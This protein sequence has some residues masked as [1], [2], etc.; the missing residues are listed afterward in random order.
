MIVVLLVGISAAMMAP[1]IMNTMAISRASRCQYDFARMLRR[2]RSEAIGTGRAQLIDIVSA[3]GDVQ[4]N[5][6]IGDSSSC[7]RSLWGAIVGVMNPVDRVWQSDYD[8][9]G[10]G[11]FVA[12]LGPGAAPRQICFEPDGDRFDRPS[13]AGVFTRSPGILTVTLD[14]HVQGTTGVDVQR[15]IVIPQFG[16]P[17]V[18]R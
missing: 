10:N 16:A 11:V 17:R 14:R 12:V 1:A 18:V 5:V 6:Y 2:A 8:A 4:M 7:T 3:A 9:A 15:Q 13:T